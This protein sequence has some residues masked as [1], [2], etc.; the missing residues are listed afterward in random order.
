MKC[1]CDK[2]NLSEQIFR[3]ANGTAKVTQCLGRL[4]L[5][6]GCRRFVVDRPE[7]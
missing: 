6:F 4:A 7:T 5:S 1:E 3:A 2:C